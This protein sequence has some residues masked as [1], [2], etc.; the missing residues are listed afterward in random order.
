MFAVL[1]PAVVHFPIAL[2]T[3]AVF[4]EFVGYFRNSDSARAVAWWSW[5]G[6]T[7]GGAITVAAGYS[8]MWRTALEPES[9]ELVHL[10]LKVGWVLVVFV[11][12][13]TL[14]RWWLRTRPGRNA[15]RAFLTFAV[16]A[17]ALTYFQGWFGGEI[18]YAY[19]A[20]VAAADQGVVPAEAAQRNVTNVANF[21]RRVPL[22]AEEEGSADHSHHEAQPAPIGEKTEKIPPHG[23]PEHHH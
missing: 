1:H 15:S 19:G 2:I 20:G 8:D 7:I 23:Q 18:A 6:A 22:M 9:H 4:A 21:L 13:L 11:V 17:L 14:W 12:A 10:H 16:L 5:I 3:F